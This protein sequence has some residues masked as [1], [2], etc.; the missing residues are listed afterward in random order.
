MLLFNSTKTSRA[1]VNHDILCV[2][3]SITCGSRHDVPATNLYWSGYFAVN[4][5]HAANICSTLLESQNFNTCET[6]ACWCCNI[7]QRRY[8]VISQRFSVFMNSTAINLVA[9]VTPSM[10]SAFKKQTVKLHS[11][12]ILL[13]NEPSYKATDWRNPIF[14]M[15]MHLVLQGCLDLLEILPVRWF[16]ANCRNK[17]N[18]QLHKWYYFECLLDEW[19][20]FN[21][22]DWTKPRRKHS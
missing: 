13:R 21:A 16:L 17:A 12:D 10:I 15:S 9:F 1:V 6:F 2:S 14:A 7:R 11:K 5:M 3:F 20:I 19:R 4:F 8:C 18:K 22:T